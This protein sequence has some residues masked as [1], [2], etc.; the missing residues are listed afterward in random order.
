M[1]AELARCIIPLSYNDTQHTG[2]ILS[3]TASTY[4]PASLLNKK[5]L[6]GLYSN[7]HVYLKKKKNISKNLVYRLLTGASRFT[8]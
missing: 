1:E 2:F 6:E 8:M 4:L 3:G 7:M 5:S